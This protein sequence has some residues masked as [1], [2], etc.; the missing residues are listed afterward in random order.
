MSAMNVSELIGSPATR[1]PMAK[2]ARIA[3]WI[4][5]GVF[6]AMMTVSGILFIVGP[7]PLLVALEQLGYPAYFLKLLG[8]AKLLGVVALLWPRMPRLREWATAGFTFDLLAGIASHVAS[9]SAAHSGQAVFA[10]GL[11][12]TSYFL[13]RR[14]AATAIEERP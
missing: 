12:L 8:M 3:A 6:A 13:R 11:L 5:T 7:Q 9:G 10:L 2:S 1:S 4:T 14:M